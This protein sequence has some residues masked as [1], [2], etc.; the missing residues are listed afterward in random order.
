MDAKQRPSVG[1]GAA[2]PAEA[3]CSHPHLCELPQAGEAS[4]VH[5]VGSVLM[6]PDDVNELVRAAV[7][8]CI[9]GQVG[10]HGWWVIREESR[11]WDW[12]F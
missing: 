5:N 11:R 9:S 2:K 6:T 1:R 10:L 8:I 3:Q 7:R 12:K 4:H